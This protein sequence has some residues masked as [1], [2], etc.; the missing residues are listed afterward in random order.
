MMKNYS[1]T[2]GFHF[3]S[4]DILQKD[5]YI[6]TCVEPQRRVLQIFASEAYHSC[7]LYIGSY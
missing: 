1:I 7:I 4:M 6:D 5:F 3:H 2:D